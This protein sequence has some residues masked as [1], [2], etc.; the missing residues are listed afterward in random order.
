MN[1]DYCT[2]SKNVEALVDQMGQNIK[3]ELFPRKRVTYIY[4]EP[5]HIDE[6]RQK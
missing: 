5:V 2:E 4:N 1:G 6:K 3:N